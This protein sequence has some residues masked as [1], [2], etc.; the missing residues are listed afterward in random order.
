MVFKNLKEMNERAT[1]LIFITCMSYALFSVGDAI[2]KDLG[3]KF[4][5]T[6]II[7][8]LSVVQFVVLTIYGFINNR[9]TAFRTEK[10]KLV[11]VRAVLGSVLA[12]LIIKALPNVELTTFY[13]L[14]FTSPLW[15]AV[16]SSVVLGD[17]L[18]KERMGVVIF[19]LLV[20][21]AVF[22][23]TGDNFNIWSVVLTLA[24]FLHAVSLIVVRKLGKSESKLFILISGSFLSAVVFTPAMLLNY[25]EA[26]LYDL[27]IF[28][29]TAIIGSLGALLNF[30]AF[31]HI[32][33]AS[34]IAP[35][36]YTQIIWGA[37][38]GYFI[39]GDVPNTDIVIGSVLITLS[40]LYL[41]CSEKRRKRRE[42]KNA[43]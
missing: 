16:L 17:E 36:H 2:L 41:I 42:I 11:F 13:V 22:R 43:I 20:I 30:H 23:P 4:H 27:S 29:V 25:V 28:V 15:L 39:F 12:I 34:I 6:Q 1:F 21:V 5:A 18:T 10:P 38:L 32:S 40:G 37:L 35:Y 31:Q 9:E 24:A 19:G 14:V 8:Y 3:D 26:D 7:V 33:S